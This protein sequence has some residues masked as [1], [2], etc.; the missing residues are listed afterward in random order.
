MQRAKSSRSG[1]RSNVPRKDTTE[2][3]KRAPVPTTPG[4][5]PSPIN[6]GEERKKI[7]ERRKN[8]ANELVES[9]LQA[10]SK[11]REG[12]IDATMI[13]FVTREELE[14]NSIA[15]CEIDNPEIFPGDTN[16]LTGTLYDPRMGSHDGFAP[17][18]SCRSPGKSCPGHFGKILFQ[19]KDASGDLAPNPI[20]NSLYISTLVKCLNCICYDC[21]RL[22][23]PPSS[24][25]T[26]GLMA[27][28]RQKRL[29]NYQKES[30]KMP[31]CT[32]G[33]G[34]QKSGIYYVSGNDPGLIV[35][36]RDRQ[37]KQG[38]PE[39]IYPMMAYNLLKKLSNEEVK[40]LG[41]TVGRPEATLIFFGLL[42]TPPN[43][44]I[45]REVGDDIHAD[46]IT[47]RYRQIITANNIIK[48]EEFPKKYAKS[49]SLNEVLVEKYFYEKSKLLTE[50]VGAIVHTTGKTGS[51]RPV[52]SLYSIISGKSGAFRSILS[53]KTGDFCARSVGSPGLGL[54]SNEVGVPQ[55]W[56]SLLTPIET[57]F[58]TRDINGQVVGNLVRLQEALERGEVVRVE[59]RENR[60]A[61]TP[62]QTKGENKFILEIGDKVYRH[63]QNG[64]LIT[65]N[66]NPSL[67]KQSMLVHVVKLVPGL[68][69]QMPLPTT[70]GYNADYDGDEFNLF[71]LQDVQ[72]RAEAME[73][74]SVEKSILSEANGGA[75]LAPTF[76]AIIGSYILTLPSTHFTLSNLFDLWWGTRSASS[77]TEAF[78]G[79]DS[80]F[81][82]YLKKCSEFKVNPLSGKSVFSIILPRDLNYRTT[83]SEP[84]KTFFEFR[85][86]ERIIGK[87]EE[88]KSERVIK[89]PQNKIFLEE[90]QL[91]Q[92]KFKSSPVYTGNVQIEEEI[93]DI[94]ML[95][96]I[97]LPNGD[98]QRT[99]LV[100][101][102]NIEREIL[103]RDGILIMGTLTKK[104]I[105]VGG[106][107]LTHFYRTYDSK[108][109]LALVDAID[110]MANWF[111]E[112]KFSYSIGIDD[113]FDIETVKKH[114]EEFQEEL[115]RIFKSVEGLLIP[116]KTELE[117]SRR[118]MI[119]IDRLSKANELAFRLSTGADSGYPM[120]NIRHA[121]QSGAKGK[122]E[123]LASSSM[124]I[125]L[126]TRQGQLIAP[127]LGQM[128]SSPFFPN[129]IYT[130]E[131][132]GFCRRSLSE[133]Y[134][135]AE[136][137]AITSRSRLDLVTMKLG[138][139]TSGYTQRRLTNLLGNIIINSVG[140]AVNGLEKG[141]GM[142]QAI[143]GDCGFE[144]KNLYRIS[145]DNGE[146]LSPINMKQ[147]ALQ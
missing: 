33:E 1:V 60:I 9:E 48:G 147:L 104:N 77:D 42:V 75:I 101:V 8:T 26:Y 49:S 3:V 20:Y 118:Q 113:M 30:L 108:T 36:N 11:I 85:I 87:D 88:V 140:S 138:T 123:N 63:L 56:K 7:A 44:R 125:G 144:P 41:F 111:L 134:S 143:Y 84:V 128:R 94:K 100:L 24:A 21:G 29:L 141:S 64:D 95:D 70:P 137:F 66:R 46:D 139:S 130:S 14:G 91:L 23:I 37:K 132:V 15:T 5:R 99:S 68:S 86:I 126:Q 114:S 43:T 50:K 54:K 106:D 133:G 6:L 2:K 34:C 76:N 17:C 131:S 16:R 18:T 59:R 83:L 109:S 57:V 103:I 47:E 98:F 110:F 102:E 74:M 93:T 146:Y 116:A 129:N 73:L 79:F 10:R 145:S 121:I 58:Q 97:I 71:M 32:S 89:K 81:D 117:E 12:V 40:A 39:A 82:T 4:N 107:F 135:P 72:A 52:G 136:A 115:E 27:Y 112:N 61:I 22:I 45:S 62:L 142:I 35:Y 31:Q 28:S 92:S 122:T 51:K 127:A 65:L 124:S 67:H 19:R 38:T 53:A 90:L 105:G 119:V 25:S 80:S 78:A 120:S 96:E 13:R 55:E 69:I